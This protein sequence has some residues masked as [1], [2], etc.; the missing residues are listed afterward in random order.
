MSETNSLPNANFPGMDAPTR[1]FLAAL[2]ASGLPP[3]EEQSIP[4][5][6]R[7]SL[8]LQDAPVKIRPAEVTD[9]TL[10]VGP[11][12][13]VQIRIVR[14]LN[15][16]RPPN[17]AAAPNHPGPL[18]VL[19]FF[20]GGGWVLNNFDAYRHL[21]HEI[22]VGAGVA[23][24]FV[25]Y[26]LSPEVRYPVALEECY[27]ATK[28]I[29]E[30]GRELNLD[31]SRLAVM[32]DSAGGNL[33]AAVS[34]LATERGGP[35]IK[36]QTLIYPVTDHALDTPSYQEFAA[37]PLLTR[38]AMQWFWDLYIPDAAQR[39][40]PTASPLRASRDA[41]AKLT[42]TLLINAELD[43]LRDD[44]ERFAA[45]LIEAGVPCTAV[46]YLGTIHGFLSL[47]IL[48][49]TPSTRAAIAQINATLRA[50]LA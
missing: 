35:E 21:V 11:S 12:G 18:P 44:G 33:S 26:T 37:G 19:M 49:D 28:W 9:H 38:A 42:P 24:V 10:P 20:H 46:R 36:H 23:L 31:P 41:L 34:L 48:A 43:P 32:G 7:G 15:D 4:D 50:A 47:N 29:A 14:P 5:A 45:R 30:H 27:A 8:A 3:I 22:A 6:R 16:V 17:Q 1:H 39:S 2:L 25:E 13:N 40:E